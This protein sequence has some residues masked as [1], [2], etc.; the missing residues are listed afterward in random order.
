MEHLVEKLRYQHNRLSTCNNYYSVWKKFNEF[1]IK[2]DRKPNT[3]EDRLILF[4]AY[5]VEEKKKPQTVK[6]YISAIKSVLRDDGVSLNPDKYLLSALTKACKL[7]NTSVRIRLPIQKGMLRVLLKTIAEM[8]SSQPYLAAL[9][10]ALFSTAYYG[11]FR[12]SELTTRTH[13]VRGRDVHISDNKEK[14]KFVL[15][16]SKTHW[17]DDKPQIII[18]S[19]YD[20]DRKLTMIHQGTTAA[21]LSEDSN[22]CPFQILRDFFAFRPR[23]FWTHTESFFIFRDRSVVTPWHMRNTLK[24]CL[25]K[26]GFEKDMYD[27]HSFHAGCLVDLHEKMNLPISL[28]KEFGWWYSNSVY[29][30]LKA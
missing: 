8:F 24:T 29:R 23:K 11:L 10:A 27:T 15:R 7:E 21:L 30:Y 2:L 1:Y 5:L 25:E 3:W 26:A 13:P 17:T 14:M 18:I 22:Y 16:T 20:F 19:R 12:V 4:V 28:V 6:S 9:Y